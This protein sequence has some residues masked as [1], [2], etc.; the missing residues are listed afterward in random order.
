MIPHPKYI[1]TIVSEVDFKMFENQLMQKYGVESDEKVSWYHGSNNFYI[2]HVNSPQ[3]K[4]SRCSDLLF[5]KCIP[6]E[7]RLYFDDWLTVEG[8]DH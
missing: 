5:Y 4:I 8:L 7:Y 3:G 6:K 1:V 2:N